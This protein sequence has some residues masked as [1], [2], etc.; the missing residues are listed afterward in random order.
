MMEL[1]IDGVVARL[2]HG[3]VELPRYDAERL[4]SVTS[5]R[6]TE[7]VEL[8]VAATAELD[9]L[10][11]YAG[12]LHRAEEFNDSLHA[13]EIVVDGVVLFSGRAILR[14][15]ER[16]AEGGERYVVEIRTEGAAWATAAATTKLDDSGIECDRVM[17]MLG[18]EESWS[19]KGAVRILPVRRDSYPE[20]EPTGLYVAQQMLLPQDYHPFISVKEI[21]ESI[22]RD[23][24]YTL[25]SRFLE[26]S[27]FARLMLSGAYRR[28]N[29][30]TA[31]AQMGFK[32]MRSTS[33]SAT[34][35]S[36]GRV[37]AWV[38]IFASNVGAIVDTVNPNVVDE[39]GEPMREA[40]S[41]GGCFN[42]EA[43]RP[44]FV[45]KREVSVAFDIDLRYTTDYRIVSSR[46]LRGFDR[47][48]V[49]NECYVDIELQNPFRDQRARVRG[50]LQYKLFIFDFDASQSYR[51]PG[52]GNVTEAVSSVEFAAGFDGAV[53]LYV[54][55]EGESAYSF[56]DGDW[57]IYEGYVEERGQRDVR[58]TIRTPFEVCTPTQPKLFND[59]YFEGAEEGQSLTLS[60]G[61]SLVPVF[62]GA[63]GYG[64]M[65]GFRDVANHN[66]SQAELLEAIAHMFNL[67]IYSHAPSRSLYV[68]PYDDFF[69]GEVYD[70]RER[71][72]ETDVEVGER[73][74]ESFERTRLGYLRADG[75]A[76]R[77]NVEDE[78][79]GQWCGQNLSYAAKRATETLPNPLFM[80]TASYAEA[81]SMAPSAELL[82]VGDRDVVAV[83]DYI[84]PRIVLYYGLQPLPEGEMWPKMGDGGRY[85]RAAF[86]APD[87]GETLCFEDRDGCEGLHR[88][89]DAEL[90]QR[91]TRQWLE[92]DIYLRPE[93]FAALFD[94]TSRG[95]TIRSQFRL[96]VGGNSSLFRLDGI[97]SYDTRRYVARCRFCR[98]LRD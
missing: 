52:L 70:W 55:R 74:V 60:A 40:F 38:P 86:H 15:V 37:D 90:G 32:A 20:P 43:G 26:S 85:P 19:D 25:H 16:M 76:E 82:T 61:C 75:A 36:L 91:A 35:N 12:D 98:L 53:T 13:A 17:S 42:F 49:G 88:Y 93:E 10:F 97:E 21:V 30:E 81:L 92:V 6:E 77:L 48:Y 73:V 50:G 69:A 4:R 63:V 72:L 59:I 95:A 33:T 96:A 71:Q 67:R 2:E 3:A 56:Y 9:A 94:P 31:Y 8:R 78:L 62:S 46:R 68:E 28:L 7:S 79:F 22:A 5:W 29:V 11:A 41:N 83:D 58:L 27:L 87:M 64:Q 89:Y 14:G 18:I 24:G 45:P 66:F 47:I 44:R 54:K 80:P 23:S 84:E 34:A 51:M 57:A 1:R 39:N 65:M